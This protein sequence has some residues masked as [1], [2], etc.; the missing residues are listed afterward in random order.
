MQSRCYLS[1]HVKGLQTRKSKSPNNA[2]DKRPQS[3]ITSGQ[4]LKAGLK[5]CQIRSNPQV[6][7]QTMANVESMKNNH[8]G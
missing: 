3:P 1:L 6:Q 5:A 4:T 7:D 8:S 2:N